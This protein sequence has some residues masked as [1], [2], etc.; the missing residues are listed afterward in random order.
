[1]LRNCKNNYG[2]RIGPD[3]KD[4]VISFQKK[5]NH[6]SEIFKRKKGSGAYFR[7]CPAGTFS[8]DGKGPLGVIVQ[9]RHVLDVRKPML[10]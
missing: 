6:V 10:E 3:E 2:Y 5:T 1:M 7:S 9:L 4:L 8:D